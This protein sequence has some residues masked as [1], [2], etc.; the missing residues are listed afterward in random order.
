MRFFMHIMQHNRRLVAGDT[1]SLSFFLLSFFCPVTAEIQDKETGGL[2]LSREVVAGMCQAERCFVVKE[3]RPVHQNLSLTD[4]I[5][6][7][8][9]PER[10]R[11]H[12]R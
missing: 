2:N 11:E 12:G 9:S 8:S 1:A 10:S 4:L 6:C 7:I 3:P 5:V